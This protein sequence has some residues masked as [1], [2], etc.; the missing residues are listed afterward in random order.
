MNVVPPPSEDGIGF[1]TGVIRGFESTEEG[2]PHP[3]FEGMPTLF[4]T[5]NDGVPDEGVW[6]LVGVT[7]RGAVRI[8]GP[9]WQAADLTRSSVV[10]TIDERLELETVHLDSPVVGSGH[11]PLKARPS[12][13]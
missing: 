1:D 3:L 4:E 13:A 10:P 8:T 6:V 2:F 5:G 7:A 11:R 9:I 12:K